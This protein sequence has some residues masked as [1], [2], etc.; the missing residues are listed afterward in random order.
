[1]LVLFGFLMG[2]TTAEVVLRIWC[3]FDRA[4][5]FELVA[6]DPRNYRLENIFLSNYKDGDFKNRKRFAWTKEPYQVHPKLGWTTRRSIKGFY[7]TNSR[8]HR[9]DIEEEVRK[10]AFTIV[11]VGDSFTWGTEVPCGHDWPSYLRRKK[12][13]Y[14][15]VNLGVGGYGIDQMYMSLE[16]SIG[17]LQPDLV[18]MAFIEDNL[19]RSLLS[20]HGYKKPRFVISHDRLVNTVEQIEDLKTVYK[21]VLY[22]NQLAEQNLMG[23]FYLKP[24]FLKAKETLNSSIQDNS[25]N[26][27]FTLNER[28][29]V[30]SQ[31]IADKN[32]SAFLL[33]YLPNGKNLIRLGGADRGQE[34]LEF[35]RKRN[36]LNVL[37]MRPF[38]V[39][40][41]THWRTRGHYREKEHIYLSDK[42][43]QR[44][45]SMKVWKQWAQ[46][47]GES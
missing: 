20:F 34:F 22:R 25:D 43:D 11:V 26:E 40:A 3:Y 36:F 37:D 18:I 2:I 35:V 13:S 45:E 41:G 1:M 28:L 6:P 27:L 19:K 7:C 39:S 9:G 14:N 10:D 30:E 21:E 38:F 23:E 31:R 8:G 33:V 42:V 46:L 17:I 12:P 24:V 32:D 5:Y 4:S 16:E 44:I 29:V 15:V 47:R